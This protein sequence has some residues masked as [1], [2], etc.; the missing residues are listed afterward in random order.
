[1]S[2]LWHRDHGRATRAEAAARK[3]YHDLRKCRGVGV[4]RTLVTAIECISADGR[5]LSPLFIWPSL[6]HRSDWT[7]YATPGWHFA[8]SA[9]GYSNSDII[10]DWYRRVFDPQTRSRAKGCPR[11]LINDGFGA[12]ESLEVFQ[13]CHD[14]NIILCRLPPYTS[15]KLQPCDVG[16]FGPLKAAYREQVEDLYCKGA[17][18]VGKQHFT[19]LYS[20]ARDAA[21]ATPNIKSG[22]PKP[23]TPTK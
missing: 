12:H 11:I 10:L 20:Q 9:S 19:F 1:M 6:T 8:C 21:F 15:H 18:T 5:C 2:T 17:N 22:W 16:L 3:Q 7:T 23:C 13:F 14:N 4:K